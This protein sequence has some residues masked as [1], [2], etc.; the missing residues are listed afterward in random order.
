LKAGEKLRIARALIESIAPEVRVRGF[1]QRAH[2]SR[3]SMWTHE[4]DG[5]TL[6]LAENVLLFPEGSDTFSL[7]DIWPIGGRKVFSAA[8]IPTKPWVPPDISCCKPG[9]WLE[10]LA[11]SLATA[12][13]EEGKSSAPTGQAAPVTVHHL[14]ELP[15]DL[16][17]HVK[18]GGRLMWKL[19]DGK[20]RLVPR[21]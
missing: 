18:A 10:S 19:V 12:L 21:E 6:V 3:P 1:H 4:R 9:A 17:Q 2:P 15:D 8:W 11:K 5:L 20:P 13:P 14:P 7:L 16:A